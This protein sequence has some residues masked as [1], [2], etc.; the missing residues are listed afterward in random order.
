MR[1]V[2]DRNVVMRRMTVVEGSSLFVLCT[3]CHYGSQRKRTRW[4]E[5][6]ACMGEKRN[7]YRIVVGKP[8]GKKH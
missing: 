6:V 5:N 4:A 1:S 3:V 8:E 7:V 2:V